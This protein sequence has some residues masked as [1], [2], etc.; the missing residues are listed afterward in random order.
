MKF[1]YTE[2]G[3]PCQ[4]FLLQLF[5]QHRQAFAVRKQ[6]W[7]YARDLRHVPAANTLQP[8]EYFCKC[9]LYYF[10]C[11]FVCAVPQ[12]PR[13]RPW[14][15]KVPAEHFVLHVLWCLT[16]VTGPCCTLSTA[17]VCSLSQLQRARRVLCKS[18]VGQRKA[19]LLWDELGNLPFECRCVT[20][21]SRVLS[22]ER[23]RFS[24]GS[25][26]GGSAYT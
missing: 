22:P 24:R 14:Y 4:R 2:S 1:E 11:M 5:Q 26:S 6:E 16:E 10:T 13:L 3:S 7:Q 8:M 9:V 25:T 20:T 17:V 18:T 12:C 15:D 21:A 23:H 19:I